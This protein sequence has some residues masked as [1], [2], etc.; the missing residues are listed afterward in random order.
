VRIVVETPA[1]LH[2]GFIDL[3]G[4]C[5]RIFG[6]I[7]VALDRPRYV[8]QASRA[9][10]S[11]PDGLPEDPEMLE[12]AR[13][14]CGRMGLE[15][16]LAIQMIESIPRHMGFGSGTQGRLAVAFAISRLAG[17]PAAVP[18]LARLVG[19]GKRSGIGVAV[20]QHGG[21]VVDAGR[22]TGSDDGPPQGEADIPP[23]IFQR[24]VPADWIFVI[25]TPP[26][27]QGLSGQ[28]EEEIFQ[29]LPPMGEDMVGRISRLT[30][31]KVIPGVLTD[32]IQGFGEAIGEIQ[33]L[34]GQHFA[35]Y[36]GG[37]WSTRMGKE[38]AVRALEHGAYAVGQSSWGPC[39]FSLVRGVEAARR[40]TDVLRELPGI[41]GSQ[42]FYTRANNQGMTWRREP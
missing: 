13:D 41:G 12:T 10:G 21:L 24:S 23:V 39:V 35:P 37:V 31:M 38:V 26:E 14:L 30:L 16:G 28:E 22:R 33:V 29:D 2:L 25:V 40:L 36:Q 15:G 42:V 9:V 20:F 17:R 1:R 27:K 8:L 34:A 6:S 32:D 19:R 5:G 18:E 3:N 11:Q 4:A 7:G